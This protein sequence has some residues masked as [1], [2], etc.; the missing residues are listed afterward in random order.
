MSTYS[1]GV[2]NTTPQSSGV[3]PIALG[4][5]TNY[6]KT[7]DEPTVATLKNKTAALDQQEMITFRS[8]PIKK[9]GPDIPVYYPAPVQDGVLYSINLQNVLRETTSAGEVIDHPIEMWLTVKHDINSAWTASSA[10]S[11]SFVAQELVRLLGACYD[12]N[13]AERFDSLAKSA[14]I[15]VAD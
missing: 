13:G 4:L 1:L 3:T 2:T 5:V 9:V 12:D 15:P 8:R 11:P 10:L 6:A 14:L 7:S